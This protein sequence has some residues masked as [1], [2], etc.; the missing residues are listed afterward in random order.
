M[1]KVIFSNG[2]NINKIVLGNFML[3]YGGN[4]LGSENHDIVLLCEIVEGREVDKTIISQ[5]I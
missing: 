5:F 1:V 3:R 2:D 4:N